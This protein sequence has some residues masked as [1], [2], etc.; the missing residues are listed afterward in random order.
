MVQLFTEL[1]SMFNKVL[2]TDINVYVTT[3]ANTQESSWACY[4]DQVI[5][6][7]IGELTKKFIFMLF[8]INYYYTY[9]MLH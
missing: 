2:P 1:G 4:M 3:A 9:Y 6:E 8:C 7:P 5:G